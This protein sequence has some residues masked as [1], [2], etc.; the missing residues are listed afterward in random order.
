[1][2]FEVVRRIPCGDKIGHLVL[3]G[4]LAWLLNRSLR[5]CIF[6]SR[7]LPLPL[8]SVLAFIFAAVEE[9]TQLAF[10]SRNFDLTD[11]MADLAGIVL[12]SLIQSQLRKRHPGQHSPVG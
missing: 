11:L 1:M 7:S 4:T 9:L 8:G 3:F 5:H 2:F 12:F 10:R 6:P